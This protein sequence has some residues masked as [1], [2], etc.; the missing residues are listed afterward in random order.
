MSRLNTLLLCVTRHLESAAD[1][2]LHVC[3]RSQRQPTGRV[4]ASLTN[5]ICARRDGTSGEE[6]ENH[7]TLQ[8]SLESEEQPTDTS[9]LG[10]A[11]CDGDGSCKQAGAPGDLGPDPPRRKGA[12]QVHGTHPTAGSRHNCL[13]SAPTS[14]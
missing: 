14:W 8:L 10:H 3:P 6:S 5:K 13:L 4:R 11:F 7:G 12:Q 2:R 1:S 9:S